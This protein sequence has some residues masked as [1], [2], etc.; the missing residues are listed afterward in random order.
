MDELIQRLDIWLN[1]NM[2]DYYKHLQP[3]LSSEEFIMLENKLG[4]EL[5]LDLKKFYAWKNGQAMD[6]TLPLINGYKL[7]SLEHIIV[8]HGIM[9]DVVNQ[10]DFDS[11]WWKPGWLSFLTDNSDSDYCI[12]LEETFEDNKGQILLF[13]SD[14]EECIIYYGSFYKWLETLVMTLELK[15]FRYDVNGGIAPEGQMYDKLYY[16]LNPGYPKNSNI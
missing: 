16:E 12:D 14:S 11:N 13:W 1:Q 15:L 9:N 4:L 5:P 2:A 10:N 3:G 6:D 7:M 8:M